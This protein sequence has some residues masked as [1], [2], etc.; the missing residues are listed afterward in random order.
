MKP[1]V[2]LRQCPEHGVPT[3]ESRRECSL[4]TAIG[5]I[6]EATVTLQ[7]DWLD[8]VAPMDYALDVERAKAEAA[9]AAL[10]SAMVEITRLKRQLA[11][12]TTGGQA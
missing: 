5:A 3:R 12:A 1:K 10:G 9:N 7:Q 2:A 6:N 8:Y 4:C 11:W